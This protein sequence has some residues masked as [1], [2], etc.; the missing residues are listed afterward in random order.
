M[1]P[2][3]WKEVEER[4]QSFY[5]IVE[6]NCDGYI[7]SLILK[8]ITAYR[9]AIMIYVNGAFEGRWLAEDC[10]E[11]RRF[12]QARQRYFHSQKERDLL[13]K[14]LERW[15]KDSKLLDPDAKYT[16]YSSCWTSFGALKRHLIQNNKEI[17]LIN[18][19]ERTANEDRQQG[20]V[21]Y[22]SGQKP[23]GP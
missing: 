12:I 22:P 8:R 16:Y 17:K 23:S 3:D 11:R 14:Y 7:V 20:K 19:K 15:C 9:N 2:Q 10:E 4:L 18:G 5:D 13:K 1:T 21:H 6:L